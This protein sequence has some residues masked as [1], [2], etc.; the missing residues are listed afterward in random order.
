MA[1]TAIDLNLE[2]DD[3]VF[4]SGQRIKGALIVQISLPV[5]I[6]G[7]IQSIAFLLFSM[8]FRLNPIPSL[9]IAYMFVSCCF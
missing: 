2:S 6:A 7:E 4:Y 3:F 8:L 1:V 9:R 5:I